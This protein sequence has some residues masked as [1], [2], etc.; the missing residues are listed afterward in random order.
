[1]SFQPLPLWAP[2][3]PSCHSKCRMRPVRPPSMTWRSSGLNPRRRRRRL[4]RLAR[5]GRTPPSA[6]SRWARLLPCAR[7]GPKRQAPRD[8]GCRPTRRCARSCARCLCGSSSSRAYRRGRCS[9]FSCARSFRPT[10]ACRYSFRAPRW[11]RRGRRLCSG[12]AGGSIRPTSSRCSTCACS[13]RACSKAG[14]RTGRWSS[15]WV[16]TARTQW[17]RRAS[18]K[19]RRGRRHWSE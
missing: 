3:S 7:A 18:G 1:M 12:L 17:S 15:L 8:S 19:R 11:W 2:T 9:R 10:S 14:F 5:K 4:H 6:R 16:R 13:W